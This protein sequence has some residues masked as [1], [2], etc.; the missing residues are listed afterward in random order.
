MKGVLIHDLFINECASEGVISRHE[1]L[2]SLET[3]SALVQKS[4]LVGCIR[5][6]ASTY[7]VGQDAVGSGH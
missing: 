1:G 4:G 2:R 5:L 6:S 3:V 7:K